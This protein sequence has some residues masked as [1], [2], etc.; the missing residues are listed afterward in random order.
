MYPTHV[1]L[2]KDYLL[3]FCLAHDPSSGVYLIIRLFL[4]ITIP[5]SECISV[6][7]FFLV[8]RDGPP[9]SAL[10]WGQVGGGRV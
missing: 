9:A 8:G 7:L 2:G 4:Q 5:L 3:Y 6:F 1:I 10:R